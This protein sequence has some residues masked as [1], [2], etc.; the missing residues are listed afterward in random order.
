MC[1]PQTASTL[2]VTGRDGIRAS[3]AILADDSPRGYHG[4]GPRSYQDKT[5]FNASSRLART[6]EIPQPL[7]L[8]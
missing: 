1:L 3:T 4:V 7:A 8:P 6:A 2:D 5:R